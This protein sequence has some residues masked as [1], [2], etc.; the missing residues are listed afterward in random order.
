[1]NGLICKIV[2]SCL[3]SVNLANISWAIVACGEADT[4]AV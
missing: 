3:H 2:L 1:L 4:M